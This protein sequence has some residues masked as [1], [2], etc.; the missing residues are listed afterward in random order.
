MP[1][2]EIH[3][4]YKIR[5]KDGKWQVVNSIG[6]VKGTHDTR[7]D[8]LEQ[9]RALYVNVKGAPEM[10]ERK[11]KKSSMGLLSTATELKRACADAADMAA[12]NGDRDSQ[13]RYRRA[14]SLLASVEQALNFDYEPGGS[15]G[16]R[17]VPGI[18]GKVAGA[19]CPRCQDFWPAD[20]FHCAACDIDFG[21][22]P[23]KIQNRMKMAA[24]K[25]R[26]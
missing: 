25:A 17:S 3:A 8:A 23:E 24:Q 15:V 13:M 2:G 5:K 26:Q 22:L 21:E 19:P 1:G 18:E 4:P 16:D 9:Q 6:E 7:E 12:S 20:S 11:H 10:A 14:Q